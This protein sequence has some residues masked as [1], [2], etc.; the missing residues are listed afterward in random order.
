MR[1]IHEGIC[2]NHYG[3]KS[4]A[5]KALRQGYYWPTMRDDAK[6][7]VRSCDKCQR[8]VR[9]PHLP[10][11]KLIVISSPW[12]FA[13]WG[14]DLTGLLPTGRGKQNMQSLR[15]QVEAVNKIIKGVLKKKLEERNGA[16]VDMLS[17]VLWAYRTTQNTST[18]E[19]PFSLAFG[20]DAIIPA[21]IGVPSHKVEYFDEVKNTSLIWWLRKGLE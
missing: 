10:P 13:I 21:E 3:A 4:L 20:V 5:Q 12:P 14:V 8:F 19:T 15:G 9:V 18:S 17:G 6:N 2:G 7:M 11:E 1:E 16:W